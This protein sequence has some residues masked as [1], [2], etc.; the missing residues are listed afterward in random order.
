MAALL[1]LQA[2]LAARQP[3]LAQATSCLSARPTSQDP[4]EYP[5]TQVPNIAS[6]GGSIARRDRP[7]NYIIFLPPSSMVRPAM[8]Y[9]GRTM[10]AA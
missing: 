4:I 10:E 3:F 1:G 8:L 5:S 7:E 2:A 9:V 6:Y